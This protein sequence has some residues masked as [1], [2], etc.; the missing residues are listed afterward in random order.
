MK[1]SLSIFLLAAAVLVAAPAQAQF[2]HGTPKTDAQK[3]LADKVALKKQAVAEQN[4]AKKF[5]KKVFKSTIPVKTITAGKQLA[6]PVKKTPRKATDQVYDT[7]W[8]IGMT[9]E[10]DF[11]QF[12]VIDANGDG[13]EGSNNG[14]WVY[15]SYGPEIR[16]YYHSTNDADDWLITPGL[17]LEGGKKYF[18]T[19][20]TKCS[21]FYDETLEVKFGNAPTVEA[22]TATIADAYIPEDGTEQ[23][24]VMAPAT[25][26]VYYIGFHCI[27]EANAYYLTLSDLSVA[28]TPDD[29]SP[30][31]ITDIEITPNAEGK[32][33]AKLSFSYPT[34]NFAGGELASITGVRILRS[35]IDDEG[36]AT[37]KEEIGRITRNATPGATATFNDVYMEDT[38][39]Y[40][41][42]FIPF[43]EY[44][45]GSPATASKWI[46]LDYPTP[47][48]MPTLTDVNGQ[49]F[50]LTW[51]ASEAANGGVF[52]PEN[53][54]YQVCTMQESA[55]WFWTI[56]EP[57]GLVGE[58]TGK[59]EYSMSYPMDEDE[60]IWALQLGV[61]A[62]NESGANWDYYDAPSNAVYIGAPFVTPL[63]ESFTDGGLDNEGWL[64][65]GYQTEDGYY[66]YNTNIYL[67]NESVDGDN[68]SVNFHTGY[69]KEEEADTMLLKSW[70]LSL[71][72][73]TAPKVVFMRKFVSEVATP[74]GKLIVKA[75]TAEGDEVEIAAKALTANDEDWVKESF[76]LSSF[77]DNRYIWLEFGLAQ[78]GV[79]GNQ[80]L[81]VDN[82]HVGDLYAVDGEVNY[83]A[84]ES[85][86]RGTD[87]PV[88]VV[89]KNNGDEAIASY[90]VNVTVGDDVVANYTVADELAS[91]A[92]KTLNF[93]YAIDK[94]EQK[95]VLPV[96]VQ[97]TVDGDLDADNNTVVGQIAVTSP[98]LLP[99][100]DLN[101]DA[102][103]TEGARILTWTAPEVGGAIEVTEGFENGLNG[104]TNIDADGDG[105]VWMSHINTGTYNLTVHDG[106][107][108]V[109]SES[110][111]NSIGALTPD[112][113]LVTP[114][115]ILDG[116]FK[117][118]AAGQDENYVAEHFTV[119]VST[120][121]AIDPASFQQVSEEY[122][123]T[124]DMTEYSV[125]LSSFAGATGYIAIRHYNCTDLYYLVVDDVTFNKTSAGGDISSF[126]VY[127]NGKLL[128]QTPEVTFT[129]TDVLADGEYTY[130]VTVIYETGEESAPIAVVYTQVTDGIMQVLSNGKAFDI[131]T[132]DGKLVRQNATTLQGLNKGVY[133]V[134]GKKIVK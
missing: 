116:T 41:Y 119:M 71:A 62:S 127:R 134:N 98:A 126:N 84:P 106:D 67:V 3:K 124:A 36:V 111:N 14:K 30:A 94:L 95:T 50:K 54:L 27:S 19:Y 63:V 42:T 52:F 86:Q 20:T 128:A 51:E 57:Y 11:N 9:T 34:K 132:V 25:S 15:Y 89:V 48:I 115:A 91:L 77:I 117:F 93:T 1:K 31:E 109:Y 40:T 44:G 120:E 78:D 122:V 22:M 18:V 101:L 114:T 46:G 29:N 81:Y 24:F 103:T 90:K 83:N 133:V 65:D 70:K 108:S 88:T 113:Y 33:Q 112:N 17:N 123:A 60:E 74:A 102:T 110:Y 80:D 16:Y 4:D 56:Y 38:T 47:V 21:S 129:D 2:R 96:K 107:G 39:M 13:V 131:Y 28:Y 73:T 105:N 82:I 76:D 5:G 97:L 68:G 64:G 53:V 8:S 75:I 125:D 35:Q 99:V 6:R 100:S 66:D 45:E 49:G 23:Q 104:F 32:A 10:A 92:A 121:S 61:V 72:G 7:P 87:V 58:V 43:N 130:Q 55:D 85:A 26:G 79:I 59:T 37:E 118:W 12:T 69:A